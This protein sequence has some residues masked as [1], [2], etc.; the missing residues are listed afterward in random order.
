MMQG[1]R[2]HPSPQGGIGLGADSRLAPDE[3][4]VDSSQAEMF[5]ELLKTR[6]GEE[7]VSSELAGVEEA[8]EAIRLTLNE[9]VA[10]LARKRS[11]T[12]LVSVAMF[13]SNWLEPSPE[14]QSCARIDSTE[15]ETISFIGMQNKDFRALSQAMMG[16]STASEEAQ[17]GPLANS[18]KQMLGVVADRLIG[19]LYTASDPIETIGMPASAKICQPEDALDLAERGYELVLVKFESV[20]GALTLPVEML[21]P[22]EILEA[23]VTEGDGSTAR[24]P[25]DTAS[26]SGEASAAASRESAAVKLCLEDVPVSVNCELFSAEFPLSEVNRLKPGQMLGEAIAMSEI[27][28]LDAENRPFLCGALQVENGRLKMIARNMVKNTSEGT[29]G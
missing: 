4:F 2:N 13:E 10:T 25:R 28:I 17:S 12:R 1:E 29:T 16:I 5:L 14:Q 26:R 9:L 11:K 20:A 23:G 15:G 8:V 19:R 21:F 7:E 6:D 18:E 22:L 27:R 24:E 3:S